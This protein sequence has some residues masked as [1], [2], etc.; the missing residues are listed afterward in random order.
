MTFDLWLMKAP[1]KEEAVELRQWIQ[2]AIS[3]GYDWFEAAKSSLPGWGGKVMRF[4][5]LPHSELHDLFYETLCKPDAVAEQESNSSSIRAKIKVWMR[6]FV[7]EHHLDEY[8][9]NHARYHIISKYK[10]SDP[11]AGSSDDVL[12]IGIPYELDGIPK[13]A[14]SILVYKSKAPDVYSG[15]LDRYPWFKWETEI[16][17]LSGK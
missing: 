13:F 15:C 11:G 5:M 16:S 17:F 4:A 12:H 7:V 2:D 3:L 14:H 10:V 6:T 8:Q 9:M 1:S